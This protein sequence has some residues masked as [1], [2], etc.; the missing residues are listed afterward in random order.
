MDREVS[1]I[2]LTWTNLAATKHC[3]NLVACAQHVAES[4]LQRNVTVGILLD[5]LQVAQAIVDSKILES[6]GVVVHFNSERVA[7]PFTGRVAMPF[8]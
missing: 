8:T 7:M 5:S 1:A 3:L 6:R 2:I 4:P